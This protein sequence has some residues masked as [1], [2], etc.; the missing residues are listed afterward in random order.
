M[1]NKLKIQHTPTSTQPFLF[2][3]KYSGEILSQGEARVRMGLR[4]ESLV[5]SL[6]GLTPIPINGQY[7]V[8]F[9]AGHYSKENETFFEIKSVKAGGKSPIYLFRLEKE[10]EAQ[11]QTG[12]PVYYLFCTHK[13]KAVISQEAI[14]LGLLKG[15]INI[16]AVPLDMVN[17]MSKN[18]HVR[19]MKRDTPSGYNRKGYC[20][21]YINF[22][23]KDLAKIC[24]Y[25]FYLSTQIN[26][27]QKSITVYGMNHYLW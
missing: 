25:T 15:D 5:C 11:K 2:L 3:P 26:G 14:T 16:Y 6:L 19:K 1:G 7:D 9:D 24:D 21:G 20:E 18:L 22:P 17:K 12:C 23:V 8:N 10:L 27:E 13:V 4:I